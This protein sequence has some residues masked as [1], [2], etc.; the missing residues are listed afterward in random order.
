M[1]LCTG[2]ELFKHI[3]RNSKLMPEVEIRHIM[4]KLLRAL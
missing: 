3:V 1:E 2:G 4:I